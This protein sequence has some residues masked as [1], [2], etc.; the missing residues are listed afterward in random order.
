MNPADLISIGTIKVGLKAL[1]TMGLPCDGGIRVLEEITSSPG[2]M[3][4]RIHE[5]GEMM[6]S[7]WDDHKDSVA[8]WL[9][10]VADSIGDALS[11]AADVA[12]DIAESILDA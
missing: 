3:K 1:K 11:S 10:N 12:G 9:G 8:E 5:A 7:F 2:Y 4:Y 6:S